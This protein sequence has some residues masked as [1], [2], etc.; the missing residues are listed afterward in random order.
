MKQKVWFIT[1]AAKGFG[2][3]ICKAALAYGDLVVATAR[4]NQGSIAKNMAWENNI[5]RL[6]VDVTNEVQVKEAVKLAISQFG[7]ID[8]LVNNAGYG[9]VAAVEEASDEEVK[10]QYETNVFGLLNVTRAVLPYMRSERSGHIINFS[11]LFGYLASI[12]GLGVYAST[13]FAVEGISE[14]L[15]A[16]AKI[17]GIHVT[18]VAPGLF[19]TSFASKESYESSQIILSDY[20]ETV[21][22]ARK[23]IEQLNGNQPGDPFKL[24]DVIMKLANS[25]KPPLHLPI[26]ADAIDS[27]RKKT[28]IMQQEVAE[29]EAIS[30][31]TAHQDAVYY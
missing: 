18:S 31:S 21:G 27:F 13:K 28:E 15:A 17:F 14:G 7:R 24:A 3:E 12:P 22:N 19:S 9:L 16:E 30:K 2:L 29:W 26:G 20:N 6:Q 10:K 8:V 25:E 5:L 23:V 1:G 4:K 11:S